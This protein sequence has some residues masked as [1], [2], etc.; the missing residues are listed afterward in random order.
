MQKYIIIVTPFNNIMSKWASKLWRA[1]SH[2]M[3]SSDW[4]IQNLHKKQLSLNDA[5]CYYFWAYK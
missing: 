5:H 2:T 4:D 3:S 1:E